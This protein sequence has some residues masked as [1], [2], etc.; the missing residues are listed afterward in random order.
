MD[1]EPGEGGGGRVS[2]R[3][4]RRFDKWAP[5]YDDNWLQPNFFEPVHEATLRLA[6][7]VAPRPRRVLDVGCGT[8]ALMRRAADRFPGAKLVGADPAPG[9]V[10]AAREAMKDGASVSFV[11]APVESLPFDDGEFD[12]VLST[13][14]FNHWED[15]QAGFEEIARVLAPGGSLVLADIFAASW[16]RV[17]LLPMRPHGTFRTPA[18][19]ERML[20]SAGLVPGNRETVLTFFLGLPVVSAVPA[21]KP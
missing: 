19:I 7:R 10:A 15:Q 16:L 14:S 12:L 17:M 2:H 4:I 5:T 11:C 18:R 6:A 1:L 3:D 13:V 21:S 8:G 9:M 20:R